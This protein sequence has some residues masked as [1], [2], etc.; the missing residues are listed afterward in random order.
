MIRY[1]RRLIVTAIVMSIALVASS[2]AL[3]LPPQASAHAQGIS[4]RPT[5]TGSSNSHANNSNQSSQAGSRVPSQ[6]QSNNGQQTAQ[7]HMT[8]GQLKA[9]QNRQAAISNIISR[10]D[11]RS[12]N[13]LNLFTTIATRVENFYSTKS[14][15]V[16][17]YSQLVSAINS[18]KTLAQNNLSSLQTS[19]SFTCS[20]PNPKG[21]VI[22]FQGYLKTEISDLQNYR[23]TVKNLIVAIAQA[24]NV[25]LSNTNVSQTST[26][27]KQ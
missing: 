6:A 20:N 2:T 11:T 3:A 24:N 10:I 21:M 27:G 5:V 17:N 1:I 8:N 13:Q 15:N 4:N 18:A 25:K 19:S 26:G 9:C 16:S 7:Q 23:M 14:K 12:Q 22:A